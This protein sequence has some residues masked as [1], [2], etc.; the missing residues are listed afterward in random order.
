MND[1]AD[2]LLLS[3]KIYP[4]TTTSNKMKCNFTQSYQFQGLSKLADETKNNDKL[5]DYENYRLD[6]SMKKKKEQFPYE[7]M[8]NDLQMK[9]LTNRM[10]Q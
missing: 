10:S 6:T 1:S 7:K 8:Y 9:L 3:S 5:S 4:V 2:A